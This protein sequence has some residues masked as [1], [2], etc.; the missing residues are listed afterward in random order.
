MDGIADLSIG[1]ME[2][3]DAKVA[4]E[5]AVGGGVFAP[6]ETLTEDVLA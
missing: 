3:C 2:G 6:V 1:G 4:A 5:L